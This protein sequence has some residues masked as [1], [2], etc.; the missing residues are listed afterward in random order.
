[1]V[2][3]V[4]KRH[5]RQ[6]QINDGTWAGPSPFLDGSGAVGDQPR[7]MGYDGA[8]DRQQDS[9]RISLMGFFPR[10]LSHRLSHLKEVDEQVLMAD[11]T[12]GS[13]FGRGEETEHSSSNG[14]PPDQ[15][16]GSTQSQEPNQ[17]KEN[18][19]P[20]EDQEQNEKQIETQDDATSTSASPPAEESSAPL[21][22]PLEDISQDSA[23]SEAK[24][25]PPP[26]LLDE[27][28]QTSL[29]ILPPLVLQDVDL[30]PPGSETDIAPP[31]PSEI[32]FV[33]P[34]A[35]PLPSST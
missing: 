33:P 13:T 8:E 1:M 14:I 23:P 22:A 21:P 20:K 30:G 29:P 7:L 15:S 24:A 25:T 4:R 27:N 6:R 34:P 32:C 11:I 16:Q 26:P 10:G 18:Q 19:E 5:F 2:I 17:D 12:T 31:P 35:P 28:H 9:K 3:M